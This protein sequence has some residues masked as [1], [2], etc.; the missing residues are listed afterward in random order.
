ML[1]RVSIHLHQY[2]KFSLNS[3]KGKHG[4]VGVAVD[5]INDVDTD[6]LTVFNFEGY[7]LKYGYYTTDF[8]YFLCDGRSFKSGLRLPY[9]DNS[10]R[11]MVDLS[12]LYKKLKINV[13]NQ[14]KLD[15]IDMDNDL[16]VMFQLQKKNYDG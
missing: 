2:G 4:Y 12:L 7:T 5:I 15:D 11:N 8:V 3:F 14:H 1:T 10:V 16:G 6:T 9:D 13:D